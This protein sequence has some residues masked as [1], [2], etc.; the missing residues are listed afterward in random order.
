MPAGV[1]SPLGVPKLLCISASCIES[2]RTCPAATERLDDATRNERRAIINDAE[3][4][5]PERCIDDGPVSRKR[6]VY[7]K[8]GHVLRLR[9]GVGLLL[10]VV[11][12][13]RLNVSQV[14]VR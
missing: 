13:V 11:T 8:G 4:D 10:W 1:W 14:A 12:G 2:D 5:A 9:L 7:G 6:C 3:D